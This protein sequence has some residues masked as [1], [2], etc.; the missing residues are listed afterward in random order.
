MW[1]ERWQKTKRQFLFAS[2]TG[3]PYEINALLTKGIGGPESC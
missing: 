3:G 1:F 2:L